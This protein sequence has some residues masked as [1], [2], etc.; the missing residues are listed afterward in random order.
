MKESV[1]WLFAMGVCVL[2]AVRAAGGEVLY[3][4]IVLPDVWPPKYDRPPNDPM[5]V[6]YLATVC[7]GTSNDGVHWQKPKLDF[8]PGTNVLFTPGLDPAKPRH[9][10]TLVSLDAGGPGL[11]GPMYTTG[12]R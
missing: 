5:P 10:T 7:C 1:A 8:Q 2:A 12:S 6:P 4:G 3:N 9:D 11:S